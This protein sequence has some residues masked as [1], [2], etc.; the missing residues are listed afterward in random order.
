M[1]EQWILKNVPGD[2]KNA[3]E[4]F[5][6]DPLVAKVL[7]NRKLTKPEQME[8]YL[9]GTLKSCHSPYLLRDVELA[10]KY[11][12]T[13]VR[14]GECISIATDYDTDGVM[15]SFILKQ[16]I[17]YLGGTAKI[18]APDRVGE[19]YGLNRRI[20]DMVAGEGSRFLIT[21]DNGIAA[22]DGVSYAKSL[23]ITVV[24]TD[25][26]EVQYEEMD[27]ERRYL[28]PAADAIV[29]PKQPECSYPWKE[30][31]GAVVVYKLLQVLFVLAGE[32]PDICRQWLP[33][34][35]IATV[36]DVMLLQDENRIIVK[37]G[38]AGM[39][40]CGNMGLQAL[41]FLAELWDKDIDSYHI[42]FVIGPCFNAA[43]RLSTMEEALALLESRNAT[44]ARER[45][46]RLKH[47]NDVRKDMTEQGVELALR[48]LQGKNEYL[49]KILVLYLEEIHESLAGIIAG[50]IKERYHRPVL[51][52]TDA[53]GTS[54]NGERRIKG[55]GRSIEEYNMFQEI[56]ACRELLD[57][58]GGHPMAAGVTM[59]YDNLAE[60]GRRLN[61]N[62]SLSEED[63]VPTVTIDS[64]LPLKYISERLVEDLRLLEP[65]GNGNVRPQFAGQHFKIC[66]GRVFG[67]NSNVLKMQVDDGTKRMGAVLFGAEEICRFQSFIEENFGREE[68]EEMYRGKS[69]R[70]DVGLVFYP[71]VDEYMGVKNLQIVIRHYCRIQ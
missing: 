69:R 44:Q 10:A 46:E 17:E 8:E 50:R 64:R 1:K 39:K 42:G 40:Q 2:Y 71:S 49:D 4:T 67:K 24:V 6:I 34:A 61:E 13:A 22:M 66:G 37:E 20:V 47:I 57:R 14:S 31:C 16:G 33:F 32:N 58:F 54:G 51:V 15:S 62:T 60:F 25:H 3:G 26:H 38:L 27:G 30:I 43:G 68:L 5:G 23:G 55:S 28:Y 9:H 63:F 56:S 41:L 65:F 29:N 59:S 53:E 12:L 70:I 35:A 18:Y 45:A 19:G 21:C 36:T 52:F 7:Y 48:K 11:I